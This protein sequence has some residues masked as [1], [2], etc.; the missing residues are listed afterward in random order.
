MYSHLHSFN[1]S[2]F[3]QH[4]VNLYCVLRVCLPRLYGHSSTC[5]TGQHRFSPAFYCRTTVVS[6]QTATN[7]GYPAA[8][9]RAS[10]TA[11][12]ADSARL[13]AANVYKQQLALSAFSS[14]S[15][16]SSSLDAATRVNAFTIMQAAAATRPSIRH[17]TVPLPVDIPVRAAPRRRTT[18]LEEHFQSSVASA[19]PTAA[20]YASA[21][22]AATANTPVSTANDSIMLIGRLLSPITGAASS[23]TPTNTQRALRPTLNAVSSSMSAASSSSSSSNDH[24]A[25]SAHSGT[26]KHEYVPTAAEIAAHNAELAHQALLAELRQQRAQRKHLDSQHM[27]AAMRA[28][29]AA[30]PAS[31]S[32]LSSSSSSSSSSSAYTSVHAGP[33]LYGGCPSR[34]RQHCSFSHASPQACRCHT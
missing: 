5:G 26:G 4:G 7:C 22:S 24:A 12:F 21:S 6:G 27:L 9:H 32:S 8:L 15:S 1:L 19:P 11:L 29:R 18:T 30:N 13:A 31:S 20:S 10:S 28:S 17:R 33:P 16:S 14:T 3:S 23:G 2:V 25:A 34:A